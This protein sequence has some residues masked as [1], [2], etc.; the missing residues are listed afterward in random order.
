MDLEHIKAYIETHSQYISPDFIEL[1]NHETVDTWMI[2]CIDGRDN[3][4]WMVAIPWASIGLLFWIYKA[5]WAREDRYTLIE[6]IIQDVFNNTL[7]RHSD[8]HNSPDGVEK[9]CGCGCWHIKAVFAHPDEYGLT[10][11]D[12]AH[13]RSLLER[14]SNPSDL[15]ASC[16]VEC[17][18][19]EHTEEAILI[20][21]WLEPLTINHDD[22]LFAYN[23]NMLPSIARIIQTYLANQDIY[24]QDFIERLQEIIDTHTI[25]TAKALAP[26]LPIYLW[27]T[28]TWIVETL[29]QD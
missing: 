4:A 13:S 6:G 23:Q 28:E 14:Y 24:I 9:E 12:I 8:D 17:L 15:E 1:L 5:L 16:K 3:R 20:I 19:G 29:S 21:A 25:V 18:H 26:E 27:Q 10:T 2:E 22:K 11:D 7:S